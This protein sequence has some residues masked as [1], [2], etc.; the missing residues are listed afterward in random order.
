[1]KVKVG[2]RDIELSEPEARALWKELNELYGQ[3][4]HVVRES[5]PYIPWTYS[6]SGS[7]TPFT[8]PYEVMCETN[9]GNVGHQN[10]QF[11]ILSHSRQ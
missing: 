1:M 2:A 11:S 9:T 8:P 3:K 7:P 4:V 5:V 6:H 10:G